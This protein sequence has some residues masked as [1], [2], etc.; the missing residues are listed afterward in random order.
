MSVLKAATSIVALTLLG[1]LLGFIRTMYVSDLYGTGA[2]ADAYFT[3]LT[4]PMTLFMVIPGAINAVLIPT[5]RGLIERKAEGEREALYGK[6]LAM[7]TLFFLVLCAAGTALSPQIAGWIGMTGQ[8]AALTAELLAWMWPSV[9]FIGVAGLWASVI[10]AHQ[11]FFT[12]ALGTV[13]NGAVVIVAMYALVPAYGPVGLAIA[14]TLGY[15]AA[16]VPMLPTLKRFGYATRFSFQWKED[17]SLKGMGE[18]VIPIMIGSCISQATTFL[19]RGLTAGLGEGK[20]AAL[21]YANQIFQLP[22]G[23]FVGAFTLPLFPLLASYV[24]RGEMNLMKDTLQKGLA[25]L[26]ML[27]L[28]VTIG[29]ILFGEPVIRLFF[30]RQGGK[31]DETGVAWTVLGLAFYS[32]GLFGLAARDLLTRAFYALDNT[33]TPV[34]IGACGIL[35]YIA[36]AYA[37]I[38]SLGHGGIALAASISAWFQAVLLFILLA[39]RIGTPVRRSF[40]LTCGKVTVAGIVMGAALWAVKPFLSHFH[41]LVQTVV[42][43][44]GAAIVYA[45][46]LILLRE[47]MIFDVASKFLKRASRPSK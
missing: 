47:S 1:R 11:H 21:S 31:F 22:L 27:M 14:T 33:R 2:A 32:L 4:I 46:V 8:R 44:G 15:I 28:P 3:A 10:N 24:K 6:M 45:V 39:K 12:P 35:V 19:E 7:V 23:I 42:G 25:Y 43:I 40:L 16:A 37:G 5:M 34:T 20:I 9:F 13:T 41:V 30:V 29:M 36:S 26:W 17:E 38:P 18:R